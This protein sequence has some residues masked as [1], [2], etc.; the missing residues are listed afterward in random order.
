MLYVPP[1]SD[2][3]PFYIQFA[4]GAAKDILT[5][6]K[7]VIKNHEYPLNYK[8]KE[9]YKNQWKDAHGDEEFIGSNGLYL[10]AFTIKFECAMF[11]SGAS[12][13][14]AIEDLKTGVRTFQNAL[15][16]GMFKTYDSWTGYGFQEVR[17][18]EFPTPQQDA[19]KAWDETVPSSTPSKNH[20]AR[21]IFTVTLKINDPKTLMK[22]S[23]GSI[24][25]A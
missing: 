6:Y 14:S 16:G 7:V 2:Y 9:P 12:L 11:A 20:K 3:K 13:D 1:I 23:N 17:L 18:S 10:E 5:D 21:V 22:L 19:Y 24:V 15:A 8:A 25:A 4:S